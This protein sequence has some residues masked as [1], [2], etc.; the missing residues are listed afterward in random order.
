[1]YVEWTKQ[2]CPLPIQQDMARPIAKRV[3][4]HYKYIIWTNVYHKDDNKKHLPI[5]KLI[6]NRKRLLIS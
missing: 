3:D 6:R 1:M 4:A 2:K 5:K